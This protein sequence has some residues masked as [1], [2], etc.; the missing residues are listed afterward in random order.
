MVL[1]FTEIS[2]SGQVKSDGDKDNDEDDAGEGT[3]GDFKRLR[4]RR[5]VRE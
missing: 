4:E 5:Y 1:E 2:D 3:G